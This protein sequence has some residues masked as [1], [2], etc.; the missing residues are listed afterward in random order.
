M[1]RRS[2]I[3]VRTK[4]DLDHRLVDTVPQVPTQSPIEPHRRGRRFRR[5]QPINGL[6]LFHHIEPV[7]RDQAHVLGI[8]FEQVLFSLMSNQNHALRFNRRF[9]LFNL[10]FL[11]LALLHLGHERVCDRYR[12]R[13]NN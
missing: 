1:E 4:Y 10:G 11:F 12:G 8:V 3:M 13:E 2:M 5:V 6:T 9:Q 7:P